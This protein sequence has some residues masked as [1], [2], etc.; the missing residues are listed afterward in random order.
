MSILDKRPD[1]GLEKRPFRTDATGAPA[2][3]A[4]AEIELEGD[5]RERLEALCDTGWEIFDRFDN[6]IRQKDFHAFVAADYPVVLAT[7]VEL[8]APGR[9]FLEW[10]SATGV[11]TIMAD[12]LGYEAYGIEIDGSLVEQAR[13][14]AHRS[15][16]GARFTTGSF[17]PAGYRWKQRG[18]D[19]RL[20]T[21]ATGES[22][23]LQLGMPLEDFDVVFG[24]PWPGEEGMM[25]DLM[26]VHGRADATLLIHTPDGMRVY[27][28]GV[29]AP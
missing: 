17:L 25:L 22:G 9:R 23:Y 26:R 8:R 11:I 1:A 27:R 10:G 12:L 6:E 18:G 28:G 21:I 20:G 24:Y 29:L 16:S 15:G 7:L 14:L 19:E 5:L 2:G 4:V 13:E 3:S